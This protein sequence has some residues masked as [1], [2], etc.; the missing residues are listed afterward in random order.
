LNRSR[1]AHSSD[2]YPV[3]FDANCLKQRDSMFDVF[4]SEDDGYL[5]GRV[6]RGKITFIWSK[7]GSDNMY[8]SGKINRQRTQIVGTYGSSEYNM[9][10]GFTLS[11]DDNNRD[12]TI[13]VT[14]NKVKCQTLT[15]NFNFED[16]SLVAN[17]E[18][19]DENLSV[20]KKD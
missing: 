2:Q 17:D 7:Y 8:F 15:G 5:S 10:E 13:R 9:A 4:V 16:A 19:E 14:V 20:T 11:K 12:C 18:S 1:E 3:T 6:N